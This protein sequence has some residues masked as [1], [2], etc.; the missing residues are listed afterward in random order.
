MMGM[1]MSSDKMTYTFE[2][3]YD[4]MPDEE[5]ARLIESQYFLASLNATIEEHT[6]SSNPNERIKMLRAMLKKTAKKTTNN[7]ISVDNTIS[8]V[9]SEEKPVSC[10]PLE[11][12]KI[13]C[14][15]DKEL[16]ERLPPEQIEVFNN[17][18]GLLGDMINLF[19]E[20]VEEDDKKEG[21]M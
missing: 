2:N 20:E 12:G 4:N 18:M 5:Y 10:T 16:A 17:L 6:P 11:K 1:K 15:I 21:T 13:I 3:A 8:I 14:I 7:T 9:K 19:I